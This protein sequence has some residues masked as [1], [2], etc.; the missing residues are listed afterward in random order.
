[1]F[2]RGPSDVPIGYLVSRVK[3]AWLAEMIAGSFRKSGK[4]VVRREPDPFRLALELRL[5]LNARRPMRA[6]KEETVTRRR[7]PVIVCEIQDQQPLYNDGR[8]HDSPL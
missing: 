7:L 6:R 3:G 5:F 4:V 8:P 1:M 2:G